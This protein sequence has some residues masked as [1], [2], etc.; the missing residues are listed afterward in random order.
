MILR[1]ASQSPG[2]TLDNSP[3]IYRWVRSGQASSPEGTAENHHLDKNKGD[4]FRAA[5]GLKNFRKEAKHA[6]P[7]LLM[8]SGI[9]LR[10]RKA[11]YFFRKCV[12]GKRDE[13]KP[14]LNHTNHLLPRVAG[15]FCPVPAASN[16]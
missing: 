14:L 5:G 7:V 6:I 16:H 15:N 8:K 3:A 4:R 12:I 13:T 2:G 1:A 11:V 10:L 9:S